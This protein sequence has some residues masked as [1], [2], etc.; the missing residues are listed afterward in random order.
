MKK[1]VTHAAKQRS[2]KKTKKR[3]EEAKRYIKELESKNLVVSESARKAAGASL[4][5]LT[6]TEI[7]RIYR[8]LSTSKLN[9]KARVGIDRLYKDHVEVDLDKP[10]A[11]FTY[12][13]IH[14]PIT[15]HKLLKELEDMLKGS[16]RFVRASQNLSD[17]L[18]NLMMY[19]DPTAKLTPGDYKYFTISEYT[20][21]AEFYKHVKFKRFPLDNMT[22]DLLI[23]IAQNPYTSPEAYDNYIEDARRRS[24]NSNMK[25]LANALDID[26]D[27]NATLVLNMTEILESMLDTSQAWSIAARNAYDSEQVQSNWFELG[28]VIKDAVNNLGESDLN[29]VKVMIMNEDSLQSITNY[30]ENAISAMKSKG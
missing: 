8:A 14:K 23:R 2:I 30:I 18:V 7:D 21:T 1:H 28:A 9:S 16:G 29:R 25:K 27:D 22:R 11:T 12:S 4:D 17:Q 24:A 5:G 3:Q 13:E 10:I 26:L 20:N 6:K 15:S 19:I